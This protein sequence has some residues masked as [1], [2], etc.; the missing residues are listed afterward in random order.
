MRVLTRTAAGAS[1]H[2]RLPYSGLTGW[3]VVLRFARPVPRVPSW[4]VS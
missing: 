4:S 1:G 3:E 2:T